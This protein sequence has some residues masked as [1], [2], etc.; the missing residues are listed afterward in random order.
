MI[1]TAI[2]QLATTFIS[3]VFLS[4]II[5]VLRIIFMNVSCIKIAYHE[6]PKSYKMDNMVGI[7]AIVYTSR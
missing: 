3:M 6:A 7:V 2:V 5:L 4:V 1:A